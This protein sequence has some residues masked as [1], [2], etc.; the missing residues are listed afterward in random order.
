M[1]RINKMD[2][3]DKFWLIFWAGVVTFIVCIALIIAVHDYEKTKMMAEHGLV[4]VW[5]PSA[6]CRLWKK[7]E[8]SK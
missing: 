7:A 2:S 4:E 6:G 1:E 3:G 8:D 5:D